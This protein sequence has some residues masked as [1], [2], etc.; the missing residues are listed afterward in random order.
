MSGV[1]NGSRPWKAIDAIA[2]LCV[3]R[4][5]EPLP[6]SAAAEVFSGPPAPVTH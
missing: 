1:M 6:E 3:A 4:P 5:R 2:L